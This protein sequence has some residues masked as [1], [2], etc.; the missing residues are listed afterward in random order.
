MTDLGQNAEQIREELAKILTSPVFAGSERLSQFLAFV[1][2]ETLAGRGERIKDY[3]IGVEVYRKSQ[4]FDPRTDS[5]VRT[6]ASRLRS[7][8]ARYYETDGHNDKLIISIPKGTYVPIFMAR[9]VSGSGMSSGRLIRK[10]QADPLG[11][12]IR[13]HLDTCR[14]LAGFQS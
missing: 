4:S 13:R 2:E 11:N 8:L 10:N 9:E 12:R 3:V 1:V 6:E 14:R 7:K 5:S